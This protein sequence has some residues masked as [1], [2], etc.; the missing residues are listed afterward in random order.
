MRSLKGN[1]QRDPFSLSVGLLGNFFLFGSQLGY[2]LLYHIIL[3]HVFIKSADYFHKKGFKTNYVFLV[4][5]ISMFGLLSY[6]NLRK[7]LFA[8]GEF[9]LDLTLLIMNQVTKGTYIT[10]AIHDYYTF[11]NKQEEKECVTSDDRFKK[12]IRERRIEK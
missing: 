11:D 10:W 3:Y 1:L 2:I 6:Y 8:Y 7:M 4:G 12:R 9:S 5:F